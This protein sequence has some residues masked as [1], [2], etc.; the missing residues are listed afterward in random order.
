M[1]GNI[2]QNELSATLANN[3]INTYEISYFTTAGGVIQIKAE[4]EDEAVE[5]FDQMALDVLFSDKDFLRGI[6]IEE[7]T[8]VE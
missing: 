5:I 2:M 1:K 3:Q 4:T 8:Q 7:I 6:E